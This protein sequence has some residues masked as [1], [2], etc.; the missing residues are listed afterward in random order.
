MGNQELWQ[1]DWG[2]LVITLEAE[3]EQALLVHSSAFNAFLAYKEVHQ[4]C[5]LSS[6]LF[7]LYA[8]NIM[9]NAGLDD[10]QAK[11]KI[12]GRQDEGHCSILRS[13]IT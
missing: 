12:A 4:S 10:T 1:T 3:Y 11:I 6:C 5:I 8:E 13:E 9:R 2:H 7:N